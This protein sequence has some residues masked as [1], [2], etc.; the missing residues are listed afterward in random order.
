MNTLLKSIIVTACL[1]V[2]SITAC[3]GKDGGSA[4]YS[5][6]SISYVTYYNQ[7]TTSTNDPSYPIGGEYI[8]R[9]RCWDP[10]LDIKVLYVTTYK[11]GSET[12]Y[13]GPVIWELE[14]QTAPQMDYLS[15]RTEI[16]NQLGSWRDE[17]QIED[18]QGLLS[19]IKSYEYAVV[20]R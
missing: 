13:S 2:V 17:H 4:Q 5:R 7:S 15:A 14:P 16:F 8:R 1:I 9:L 20:A 3:G 12:P 18:G 10:D 19:N 11:A 6:P